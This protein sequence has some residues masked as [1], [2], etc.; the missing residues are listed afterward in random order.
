[1][2]T[3]VWD[4]VAFD[5]M[6]AIILWN[7]E[8]RAELARALGVIARELNQRAD[9]W[10]ESRDPPLRIGFVGDLAVLFRVDDEDRVAE[11]AE[12][13]LRHRERPG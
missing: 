4:T 10:G 9:T 6:H 12:V 5:Q 1:M 13:R 7:P 8:R 11:V 3:V 2:F